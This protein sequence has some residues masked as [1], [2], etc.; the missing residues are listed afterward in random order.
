[1]TK[2]FLLVFESEPPLPPST[3]QAKQKLI[4]RE[5]VFKSLTSIFQKRGFIII[6]ISYGVNLGCF[7]AIVTLLDELIL[8]NFPV[9]YNLNEEL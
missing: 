1:M 4:G 3:A 9:N 2:E 6:F 7:A 5:N 8:I